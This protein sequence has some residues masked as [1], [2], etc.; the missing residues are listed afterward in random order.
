MI[1]VIINRGLTNT[2]INCVTDSIINDTDDTDCM[3]NVIV[4][5]N[6]ASFSNASIT[7]RYRSDPTF[8]S[9]SPMIT[10]PA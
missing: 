4:S 10:I 9:I 1:I 7:Y 6:G 8:T 5:V 2:E 3:R